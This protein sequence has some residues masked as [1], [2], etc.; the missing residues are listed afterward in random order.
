MQMMSQL[1]IR[2]RELHAL[3]YV[4]HDRKLGSVMWLPCGNRWTIIDSGC[5]ACTEE[6]ARLDFSLTFAAAE[7]IAAYRRGDQSIF[8]QVGSI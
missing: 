7:V 5:V 2:L 3:G 6:A 1:A 8:A 4:H